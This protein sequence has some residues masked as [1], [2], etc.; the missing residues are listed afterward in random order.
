M[1]ARRGLRFCP[2][3]GQEHQQQLDRWLLC[4]LCYH[5]INILRH[6]PRV[7]PLQPAYYRIFPGK[8]S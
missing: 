1:Q 7:M 2:R 8:N 5:E 4:D 3:C 6:L